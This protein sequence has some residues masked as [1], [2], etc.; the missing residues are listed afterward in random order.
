MYKQQNLNELGFLRH[1]IITSTYKND[2]DFE[3]YLA[4]LNEEYEPEDW[5]FDAFLF[6]IGVSS[7]RALIICFTKIL[8]VLV[9]VSR[10]LKKKM[11]DLNLNITCHLTNRRKRVMKDIQDSGNISTA[12]SI[13]DTSMPPAHGLLARAYTTCSTIRWSRNFIETSI[14]S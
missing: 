3:P 13:T 11:P 14:I 2:H 5:L 1:L 12:E 7:K 6:V 9:N 8:K 4:F 10:K